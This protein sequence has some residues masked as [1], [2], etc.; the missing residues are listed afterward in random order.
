M[1][2]KS[3]TLINALAGQNGPIGTS[4]RSH[5]GQVLSAELESVETAK[6]EYRLSA[7]VTI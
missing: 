2:L 7:L 4:V 6:L 3:V 5:A 1:K